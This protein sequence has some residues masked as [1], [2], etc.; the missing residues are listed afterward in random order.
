MKD[1]K[2]FFL[3]HSDFKDL[4]VVGYGYETFERRKIFSPLHIINHYSVH[5]VVKGEG[6]LFIED[7]SYPLKKGALFLCPKGKPIPPTMS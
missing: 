1:Y 5:F 2:Y 3:P 7:K 4:N 6:T